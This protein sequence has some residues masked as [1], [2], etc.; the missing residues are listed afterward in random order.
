MIPTRIAAW[1]DMPGRW[2]AGLH[3]KGEKESSSSHMAGQLFDVSLRWIFF[4]HYYAT[5][6]FMLHTCTL[7]YSR[8]CSS[9]RGVIP[10]SPQTLPSPK[11]LDHTSHHATPSTHTLH[12]LCP[13]FAHYR[14]VRGLVDI[15]PTTY[16]GIPTPVVTV[17]VDCSQL[18]VLVVQFDFMIV[19]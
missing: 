3:G 18:L 12:T 6:L 19:P 14:R 8:V 7:G 2:T 13:S 11:A 1:R 15:S 5:A 10:V 17:C 9:E 4:L 16:I